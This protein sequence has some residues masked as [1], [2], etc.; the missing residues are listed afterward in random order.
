M[1]WV[2]NM[3]NRIMFIRIFGFQKYYWF[4]FGFNCITVFRETLLGVPGFMNEIMHIIKTERAVLMEQNFNELCKV[5]FEIRKSK[6]ESLVKR[7][8]EQKHRIINYKLIRIK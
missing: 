2:E 4:E 7:F 8:D 1:L 6:A 5:K 3:Q